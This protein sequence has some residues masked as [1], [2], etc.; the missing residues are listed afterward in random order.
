MGRGHI[1]VRPLVLQFQELAR[2]AIIQMIPGQ[3]LLKGAPPLGIEVRFQPAFFKSLHPGVKVKVIV[4]RIELAAQFKSPQQHLGQPPI[5][6]R[7]HAL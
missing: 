7:Q 2:H 4:P 5:S 3:Q 6:P 1:L